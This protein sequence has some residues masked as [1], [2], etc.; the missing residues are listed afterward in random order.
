MKKWFSG[1]I[2]LF[3]ALACTPGMSKESAPAAEKYH[4]GLH[5]QRIEPAVETR[6]G[7]DRVE[8]VELF[9][10]ACP[11]CYHL[12]PKLEQWLKGKSDYVE[13]RRIPAIVGP[14]WAEQAK[15]FYTAEKLGILD[16]AH[17]ALFK[18][19]HEDGKQY[20]DERSVMEFFVG[21]GVKPEDFFAAY[22]SPEVAEK[23]SQARV[24]TVKYGIRGVPAIIVNGKYRTA[25]YYTGNQKAL[26]EVVDMLVEKERAETTG[27]PKTDPQ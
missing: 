12:E 13:L 10:Y 4:E 22:N 23:V 1:I 16:K 2:A 3:T 18:S 11:H 17:G 20:A 19:I 7:D 6:A 9:L 8:V 14:P 15:V 26:L 24:M 27:K 5:Y 21:Q 25:Q